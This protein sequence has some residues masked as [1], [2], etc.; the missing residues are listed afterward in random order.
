[1]SRLQEKISRQHSAEESEQEM[2]AWCC[3][4]TS[5]DRLLC[6]TSPQGEEAELASKP[7]VTDHSDRQ[8]KGNWTLISAWSRESGEEEAEGRPYSLF[9]QLK[10]DCSRAGLV[11]SHW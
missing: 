1:M 10:G 7:A 3:T 8:Y 9:Q 5:A 2:N 6:L 11:S 4:L